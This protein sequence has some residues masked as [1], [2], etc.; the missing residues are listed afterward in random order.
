MQK[1]PSS[2]LGVSV[3]NSI[4]M[5]HSHLILATDSSLS[6]SI[7]IQCMMWNDSIYWKILCN[8]LLSLCKSLEVYNKLLSIAISFMQLAQYSIALM[9]PHHFISKQHNFAN[10]CVPLLIFIFIF[11]Y[12]EYTTNSSHLRLKLLYNKSSLISY[13]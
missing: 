6:L 13:F 9:S 8:K 5:P 2:W 11:F 3:Y 7:C 1:V 12:Q 10:D 4:S